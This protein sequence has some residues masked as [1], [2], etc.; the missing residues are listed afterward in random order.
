MKS[1]K[2]QLKNKNWRKVKLGEIVDVSG[3]GTPSTSNPNYWGGNIAWLTPAEVVALSGNRFIT[4]T[5]RYITEEGLKNSSA[6]VMPVNSLLLTS[7]ATIGE[8]VINKILMTTNQGFINIEPKKIDI[9]FLLYW[10]K[11]NRKFLNQIAVGST[12]NE[13]SKSVFKKIEIEIPEDINE[14][15]RIASILS[16]FDDKIEVNNKIS[17][18]L[19]KMAQ[20]IFKEWFIKNQKL[21]TEKEGGLPKGWKAGKLGELMV[22]RKEKFKKYDE[23]KDLKL[24]DLGRFPRK[25]LTITTYGKGKEIKTAGIRFKK[26]DILF[27]AIRPYFHKVVMV[28]FDGVTNS[29]V[30]VIKPKKENYYSFL[31][32]ILF[33]ENIINYTSMVASGTKMPVLKWED[34]CNM[35]VLIPEEK[36]VDHF[37]KIVKNFYDIIIKNVYEN[38]KLTALRDLLLPKLMNEEAKT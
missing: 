16:A 4:K 12:F 26:G 6:K 27:G 23:W 15:K 13:L 9:I 2:L 14:Q 35:E 1:E 24:L 36:I 7:R 17:Q 38:Q 32:T 3:G 10:L 21:Q 29:S 25:S 5:E 34:L 8:V 30:F 18:T 11:K 19:E 37:H 20:A 22:L 33:S 31:V 28:P